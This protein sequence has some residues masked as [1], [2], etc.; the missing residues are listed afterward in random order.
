[1]IVEERIQS[2]YLMSGTGEFSV[3]LPDDYETSGK[4]YPLLFILHGVLESNISCAR[5]GAVTGHFV[6]VMPRGHNSFYVN[7]FGFFDG[8][9]GHEY[10]NFFNRELIPYVES[11]YRVYKDREH[12]AISGLSM[13]GY[14]A[15][16]QALLHPDRYHACF[17]ISGA[18]EGLN[19]VGI[20]RKVPSIV[21]I[22]KNNR[23]LY[24]DKFEYLPK[25]SLECGFPDPICGIANVITHYRLRRMGVP[26]RY[27][28]YWGTH[29]WHLWRKLIKKMV[30]SLWREYAA[31]NK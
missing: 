9:P 24:G 28:V 22:I 1:M 20:T 30:S 27:K 4:T 21:S 12:T 7:G 26:H 18:T 29:D 5:K 14:G 17:S 6:I 10:D 15:L 31:D 19:C 16:R 23:S 11:H 25:L 2:R 3:F 8:K 13:G